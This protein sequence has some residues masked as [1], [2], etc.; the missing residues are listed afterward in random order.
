MKKCFLKIISVLQV[1]V[2]VFLFWTNTFSQNSSVKLTMNNPINAEIKGGE[3]NI[4]FVIL[5]ANQTAR[6]EVIQDG[7]D[8]NFTAKNPNGEEFIVSLSPSGLFGDELILVTAK[9]MGEYLVEVS[10]ASPRSKLGKYTIVLKEVRPS[11]EE[12]FRINEASAKILELANETTT[13]RYKG[14]IEGL[15]EAIAKWDEVIEVSRIKKDKVWEGVALN[16]QGLLYNQLG[17]FQNALDLYLKSLEIWKELKNLQYEGSALNNIGIIYRWL[18]EN[19]KAISYYNRAIAIQR[20]TGDRRSVGIYLNNL[21]FSY[22]R[23]EDYEKA[24]DIFRQSLEIKREDERPRGKRSVAVTLNN[25]GRTLIFK[26]DIEAGLD[27]LQQ[28]LDLRREIEHHWGVANSLLNLGTVQWEIGRKE[29]GYKNLTEANIRSVEIGDRSLESESFYLLAVAEQDRGNLTK[30]IENITAGLEVIE[31]IRGELVG[32]ES[33]YAYFSTVQNYYE[34]YTDL[35]VSRY[36]KTNSKDDL[37][38]ALE[39]SERSR[40]RSLVELL[41]EAKVDFRKGIDAKL[42]AQQKNLEKQINDKYARRQNLLSRK[43]K[44]EAITKINNE[45]NELNL[46]LEKLNLK[47]RTENPKFA[48]LAEGTTIN[49]KEIQNLL[50]DDSV[51][52]EYKLGEKRSFAWLVTKDS[53]DIFELPKRES[54]NSKAKKFYDL[55]VKNKRV[56]RRKV[57]ELAKDLGETLLAPFAKKI[58]NKKLVIVADGIL[59]YLPFSALISPESRVQSPESID[60]TEKLLVETN[61]IVVLPSASVLAQLRKNKGVAKQN[62]KTIAI[63][64]DPVFD[65]EDSRIAANADKKPNGKNTAVARV[66]RDFQFGE[67]L[68]R[69]LASRQEARNISKFVDENKSSVQTG[70]D[71]SIE[72]IQTSDLS[73]YQILHIATHGL[74][75]T[76]RPELSGLVFSLYNKNGQSQEGFLSLNDIYNLNLSSDL[77]VLSACQTA[78]GKDVRGEGLIGI[79]RGFL[80]AGTNRVVASLWKVDD[81]ATAEFM[82]LFYKNHLQKKMPASKALQQAKIEMKKI[83]RY[84]SPFYWSAFTLLGD[85]Q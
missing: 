76:K 37:A 73:D 85:W 62:N 25:L 65:K 32:N 79:S 45:I 70:F 1:L 21:G 69:L 80:Y 26:G 66:L 57:D 19:E 44:P 6:V 67:N 5:S 7:I 72:N 84:E 15:R 59:Q 53:I 28:S 41:Q 54:I 36:E 20:E 17:E 48:D 61:E 3:T 56:E 52:L 64:A 27:Y 42:L 16:T 49:A 34:L 43:S 58:N 78:L 10:P 2:V 68:P 51:L 33:R 23:L 63:F 22:M 55:I 38:L 13:L 18:G 60:K 46:Q 9:E 24:E 75:N 71:A 81:S 11:V 50:D 77:V 83:K 8:V 14:T 4:Y 31:R 12:D 30:A 47:I 74:L 35:L 29:E 40:S 82:K 39:I